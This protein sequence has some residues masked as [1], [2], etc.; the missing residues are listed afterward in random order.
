[1]RIKKGRIKFVQTKIGKIIIWKHRTLLQHFLHK[2]LHECLIDLILF[3]LF[4]FIQIDLILTSR[5][6]I[7]EAL[8]LCSLPQIRKK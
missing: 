2:F 6:I 4:F 7:F 5:E 8:K 3:F 1:V